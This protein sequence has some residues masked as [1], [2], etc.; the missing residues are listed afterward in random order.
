MRRNVLFLLLW[1]VTPVLAGTGQ[2]KAAEKLS[3]SHLLNSAREI[4]QTARY[5]ALIT[6]DAS[7]QPQA[8]AMD[9]F[10]PEEDM[11]V[12]FGTNPKSRKVQQIRKDPRVTLY[13]YDSQ[14]P[15]YVTITGE[16]SVVDDSLETAT[17]WKE[18]WE[19]FYP[20]RETG[21]VLVKV[22]PER[23][24]IVSYKHNITGD[25]QT[26]LPAFV[27]FPNTQAADNGKK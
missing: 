21:Y 5:C 15:G 18:G 20:N 1:V 16:A 24:E 26:W 4:M 2:E 25:A 7:G 19:A 14:G 13:Y 10:P 9:A 3:R 6:L 23:L 11:G 27:G 22:M 17:R 12:W 8:R